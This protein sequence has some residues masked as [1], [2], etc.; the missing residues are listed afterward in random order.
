MAEVQVVVDVDAPVRR[1]WDALTDWERQ[2]DWMLGTTVRATR[3]GGHGVG[4]ELEG[5]TGV[6]RL[7]VLDTMVVETW[8]PPSRCVVRHTGRVV[9]GAGAFEVLERPGGS[10]VVWTE[11]L[12][13][14]WG[15]LGEVG[16]LLG[17]PVAVAG[18]RWSL[19]RFARAVETQERTGAGA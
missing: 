14:P 12:D 4:G 8:E 16:F 9:H 10:R 5:W 3:K 1:T 11:W 19:R 13:L 15:L 17:R 7:G 2:S 6:G 18:V